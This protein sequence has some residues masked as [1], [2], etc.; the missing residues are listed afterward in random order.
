[1]Q[2]QLDLGFCLI[3]KV[4]YLTRQ[5]LDQKSKIRRLDSQIQRKITQKNYGTYNPSRNRSLPKIK[6]HLYERGRDCS[7]LQSKTSESNL[8]QS[9]SKLI[10]KTKKRYKNNSTKTVFYKSGKQILE[11]LQNCYR[12]VDQLNQLARKRRSPRRQPVYYRPM[13][14]PPNMRARKN[15]PT[16]GRNDLINWMRQGQAKSFKIHQNSRT[17]SKTRKRKK[18]RRNKKT[19]K[20][21][22]TR[23]LHT[24]SVTSQIQNRPQKLNANTKHRPRF[25]KF[26]SE[27]EQH[28]YRDSRSKSGIPSGARRNKTA[29]SPNKP[30][31]KYPSKH[32]KT[33]ISRADST[34]TVWKNPKPRLSFPKHNKKHLKFPFIVKSL[35]PKPLHLIMGVSV[36]EL[37]LTSKD[38][39][40]IGVHKKQSGLN[41]LTES[42]MIK[43]IPPRDRSD[44][45]LNGLTNFDSDADLKQSLLLSADKRLIAFRKCVHAVIYLVRLRR[46]AKVP[47][48]YRSVA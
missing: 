25:V 46:F 21:K 18:A 44:S 36:H 33:T 38:K 5:L 20:A 26:K 8:S 48:Q 16:I 41:K 7:V 9:T 13:L 3:Q 1:M 23:S 34:S 11:R 28:F 39:H 45:K 35:N 15:Q 10:R 6:K 47:T 40:Q 42:P 17:Q 4:N 24:N 31:Q 32:S 29:H 14:I 30:T 19:T 43:V 27:Q 22:L 12:K 2:P 37:A